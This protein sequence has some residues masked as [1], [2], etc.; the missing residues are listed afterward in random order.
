MLQL[1][2]HCKLFL[3]G[4]SLDGIFG[5]GKYCLLKAIKDTGSLQKAAEQLGRGY[6]KAW[7][8]IRRAEKGIGKKLVITERGGVEGGNTRL[9]EF[10]CKLLDSWELYR[11][12]VSGHMKTNFNKILRPLFNCGTE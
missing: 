8:D 11:I 6:R 4:K 3:S 5:D 12:A 9:T 1:N 10:A 7:G 2:P